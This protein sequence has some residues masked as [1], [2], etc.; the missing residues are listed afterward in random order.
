MSSQRRTTLRFYL[1]PGLSTSDRASQDG[2]DLTETASAE[3]PR[4]VCQPAVH[5][6]GRQVTELTSTKG[7]NDVSVGEDRALLN[8]FLIPTGQ[9]EL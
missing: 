1:V 6:I 4:L 8:S 7:G 3:D 5:I 2:A 9:A